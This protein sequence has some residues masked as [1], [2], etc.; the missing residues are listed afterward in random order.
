MWVSFL[1]DITLI[2]SDGE[3]WIDV[4]VGDHGEVEVMSFHRVVGVNGT[5][6][7]NNLTYEKVECRAN[8]TN[9]NIYLYIN[10]LMYTGSYVFQGS[11]QEILLR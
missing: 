5:E 3:V 10:I 9:G 1:S 2:I 11:L 7:L 6:Q 8:K 4:P